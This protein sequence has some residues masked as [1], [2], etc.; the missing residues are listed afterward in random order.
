VLGSTGLTLKKLQDSIATSRKPASFVIPNLRSHIAVNVVK[1]TV[2][3]N[4]II[5]YIEGSDRFS[6][7]RR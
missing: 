2:T 3:S 5:G 4:N 1:D 6:K 7:T